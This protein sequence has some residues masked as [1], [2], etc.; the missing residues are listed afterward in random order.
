MKAKG[1]QIRERLSDKLDSLMLELQRRIQQK[2]S[3]EVLE[4]RSGKALGSVIKQPMST[5]ETR[6][7]GRVTAGGGPAFY[8]VYHERGGTRQ[9]EI[10]PVNKKALAFFPRG[11]IGGSIASSNS[12]MTPGKPVVRGLYFRSGSQR[13]ALKPGRVGTFHAA[14]GVVVMKVIHPPLPKRPVAASSLEELNA[15]II[16]GLRQ[17]AVEGLRA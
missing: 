3:G 14:G 6:I 12:P 4:H 8:L 15:K 16:D 13:G 11:S 9:Y 10:V 7:E 1:P 17:A 2:L 5:T